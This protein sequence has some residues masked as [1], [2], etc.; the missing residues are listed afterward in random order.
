MD[1][2][3]IRKHK[4]LSHLREGVISDWRK[5]LQEEHPYV[6]VMPSS[7]QKQKD[8]EKKMKEL[9]KAQKAVKEELISER[10]TDVF[11]GDSDAKRARRGEGGG[12]DDITKGFNPF[13][14]RKRDKSYDPNKGTTRMQ[15]GTDRVFAR[16][17]GKAGYLD[18]STGKWNPIDASRTAPQQ[19]A[20]RERQIQN[21][22]EVK[23]SR[24]REAKDRENKRASEVVN[25][26]GNSV[27]YTRQADGSTR[28]DGQQATL[29]GKNVRWKVD[30]SGKGQ[31]MGADGKPVQT[32]KT[33]TE[34]PKTEL[35]KTDTSKTDT[36]KPSTTPTPTKPAAQ[37]GD[38]AKD[39][40]TWAKANPKLAAKQAERDRT[41]GTSAST[42]P[43][44]KDMK[45]NMP[46]PK[47]K[48]TSSTN[49]LQAGGAAARQ[50]ASQGKVMSTP[51][52]TTKPTAPKPSSSMLD[53]KGVNTSMS[54]KPSAPKPSAT[55]APKPAATAP[56]PAA[57]KPTATPAPKPAAPKP[58][59]TISSPRLNSALSGVKKY[60]PK[61]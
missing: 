23:A 31:W 26:D 10:W 54:V 27:R 20:R 40:A 57:P 5:D 42:N 56:K 1:Y 12:Q 11:T 21:S 48:T 17:G 18:K 14:S 49:A 51:K 6:D 58:S 36:S 3:E 29:G 59:N 44:M 46:A 60:T 34:P 7:G 30:S 24:E 50:A 53:N 35:P 37:T 22:P 13:G 45:S 32:T 9:K 8:A 41:R 38:K 39:M 47:P 15:D 19:G 33:K 52:P 25:K 55:P 28:R 61:M 2:R 16:K 43:L 4:E